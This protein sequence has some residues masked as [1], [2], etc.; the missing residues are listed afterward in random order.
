MVTRPSIRP[1]AGILA[2]VVAAALFTVSH[3]VAAVEFAVSTGPVGNTYHQMFNEVTRECQLE[4]GVAFV[5]K[6]STGSVR[7]LERLMNNEVSA[8]VIQL[9]VLHRKARGENLRQLKVLLLLHP[10]Q[11]HIVVMRAGQ[12]FWARLWDT[13]RSLLGQPRPTSLAGLR[14]LKVAAWGGSQVTA[15][16]IRDRALVPY[17]VVHA[18]NPDEAKS[19]LISGKVDAVLA[20]GGAPLNWVSQLDSRFKLLPVGKAETARLKEDYIEASISYTNLSPTEVATVDTV[21]TTAAL[22]IRDHQTPVMACMLNAV[23]Q[24]VYKHLPQLRQPGNHRSWWSVDPSLPAQ[25]PIYEMPPGVTCL[26]G[27]PIAEAPAKP[28][29]K[30]STSAVK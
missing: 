29:L 1:Q 7:N 23:R 9:D 10:E 5:N 19:L 4:V 2:S 21:A 14:G 18:A 8:S 3:R 12:G 15:E 25:W 6:E 30:P 24:C 26:A 13:L 11:V 28:A 17:E 16:N 20:V 27:A 22:V